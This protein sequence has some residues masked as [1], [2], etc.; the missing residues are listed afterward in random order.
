MLIFEIIYKKE[1]CLILGGRNVIEEINLILRIIVNIISCIF[2][3][4]YKYSRLKL[5]E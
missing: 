3:I 2:V 1:L 5:Y 4:K